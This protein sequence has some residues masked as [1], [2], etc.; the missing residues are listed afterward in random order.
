MMR[1][2]WLW[3]SALL[4]WMGCRDTGSLA[5]GSGSQTT[6]TVTG[7]FVNE[8]GQ[9]QSGIRVRLV[10]A[11]F[12]PVS[13]HAGYAF[14]YAVSSDGHRFAYTATPLQPGETGVRM[15]CADSSGRLASTEGAASTVVDGLCAPSA[16]T[17]VARTVAR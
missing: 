11:G 5:G 4:L 17:L 6:N 8:S 13:D 14:L 9:L 16:T 2:G 12:D 1:A 3:A 7:L 15:F 10:P